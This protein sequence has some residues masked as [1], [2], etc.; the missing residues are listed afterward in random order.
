MMPVVYCATLYMQNTIKLLTQLKS[1]IAI[2]IACKILH[3]IFIV[4]IVS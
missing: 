3:V 4:E 2:G 1:A